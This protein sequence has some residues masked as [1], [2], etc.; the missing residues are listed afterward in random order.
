MKD[1]LLIIQN[2]GEPFSSRGITSLM[3]PNASS[4]HQGTI[5]CKGLG[6]RAVLNWANSVSIYTEKFCVTFSEERAKT[7]LLKYKVECDKDHIEEL[8]RIDR[9]AILSSAK[10]CDDK[11]E[12]ACWLENGYCTA[13]VLHCKPDCVESI[14]RQLVEL[15]FEELL[16]LKHIR[17]IKIQSPQANRD[18]EAV[19]ENGRFLI[20]EGSNFTEWTVWAKSGEI[21]Q[22]DDTPKAYEIAIAYNSDE[23]EREKIRKDG[24]LYSYFKTEIQM[25]FPFLVHGTFELTS[26][27]NGLVKE[28]KNNEILLQ[29]LIDFIGEKGADLAAESQGCNYDAL[30]FLL[31]AQPLYFLDREYLFTDKLKEKIKHYK[32]FPTIREEYISIDDEPRYREE[33]FDSVV[34]PRTFSKLLKHCDDATVSSYIKSL[35]IPFY[36]E[37]TLTE[38]I[39][40]DANEY[41]AKKQ[42]VILIEL[43]RQVFMFAKRAPK[44]LI[45]SDGNRVTEEDVTVYH[46][47]EKYFALPRWCKMRF[48]SSDMEKTLCRDWRCD[49]RDLMKYLSPYGGSEYSFDRVLRELI[50]QSKDDKE[51]TI[52]LLH[53]LFHEWEKNGQQFETGLNRVN[54]QV[55][56]R[57]DEIVQVSKCFFGREYDNE[58]GE[59]IISCLTKF[60]FLADCGTLGFD[61][62]EKEALKVFLA[63]LGVKFYPAIESKELSIYDYIAYKG[64]NAKIYT[65]L[66][67]RGEQYTHEDL[68]YHSEH[69]I[70]VADID[71]ITEILQKSSYIDILYWIFNDEQLNRH[72]RNRNEIDDSS[73]MWGFP[74]KKREARYVYKEQMR[75]W[76]RKKF[77][78]AEWLPAKS[79][80]KVNCSNCTMMPHELAPTVEVLNIDYVAISKLFGRA[81]KKEIEALLESLDVAEDIPDLPFEKIYEILL[82][83]PEIDRDRILGKSIY[84]KLNLHFDTNTTNRLINNNAMYSKFKKEGKVLA[85]IGGVYDYRP[86]QEVFYV[87]RKTYSD[88][89]LKNYPILALNRRAGDDKVQRLFCVKSIKNIGGIKVTPVLHA[90]ND[91]FQV[92]YQTLLP[93]IYAKRMDVDSKNKELNALKNSRILL[94]EEARTEHIVDG[95]PKYGILKDYELIYADKIAYIKIPKHIATLAELKSETKFSSAAAEVISTI[96][97]IDRDSD[98]FM[99]IFERKSPRDI[100]MYFQSTGDQTLSVLNLA[101]EKFSQQIDYEYE[102][103]RAVSSAS[104]IE[105]G[106]LN[107]QYAKTVP[108]EFDYKKINEPVGL[109]FVVELFALI[110]ID[111]DKYNESAL[112]IISLVAYFSSKISEYKKH[113][114]D[115]FLC[116]LAKAILASNGDR[117]DFVDRKKEFDLFD[118]PILN[119]I[120]YDVIKVFEAHFGYSNDELQLEDGNYD[121]LYRQLPEKPVSATGSVSTPH[122]GG[123]SAESVDYKNLFAEIAAQTDGQTQK[124]EISVPD[125]HHF[126]GINGGHKHG[127]V[128]DRRSTITKEIDGFKAEAKVYATL[129]VRIGN[130]G[131]VEWVSGNGERAGEN[132]SGNDGCGY[133]IRYTDHA[134]S[135]HY[136]EVKG[137]SADNLEFILTK[138]EVGFAQTH[139]E[140]Y[141]LWFVFIKNGIAGEPFE[142]G[143][144]F[145]FENG[146]DFF[147]NHRFSVEQNDFK[148]RAKII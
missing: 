88:D 45:D 3:H 147:Q 99:I 139:K 131:S 84:T 118:P 50:S 104:G 72:I 102:F 13:I 132:M 136:V 5:G 96:L 60:T 73:R 2:D 49:P 122:S 146:E 135:V 29:H 70:Q 140:K 42:N 127:G 107:M 14:Q 109:A 55:I 36:D 18:I 46:N 67:A 78:E 75:S 93:Y 133:D 8:E 20:Q 71:E 82:E 22:E 58:V 64:Y 89:I 121:A 11:E 44:L 21:V 16:F 6:F 53:W 40:A 87:G 69:S 33:R 24:V 86:V 1:N 9:T 100:E 113:N 51:K 15:Q 105:V 116:F 80:K 98:S 103:W 63:Q 47:P 38:M 94:V 59:R 28:S 7:D 83:L 76:L 39:N 26:E 101:K 129:Q 110:G 4:K 90:L 57:D 143:N 56:S 79:G 10:V 30:K 91:E 114:R 108:A 115:K 65:T 35:G 66:S 95:A 145:V 32:L 112:T 144:I 81:M 85:E 125:T 92:D 74:S 31:P 41:T 106:A 62:G 68:F 137:T 128:V 48:I 19:E 117:G 37:A 61:D 97:D 148:L 124:S 34:S 23:A 54:V 142:L 12:I 43:F 130:A 138:N 141:E 25:P 27:R 111:V 120:N 126:G 17:N 123:H 77:T 52:E 119:S 134:G